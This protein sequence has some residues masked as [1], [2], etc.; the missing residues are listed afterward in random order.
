MS[1]YFKHKLL[2]VIIPTKNT[3]SGKTWKKNLRK[4][5]KMSFLLFLINLLDTK[6]I[7]LHWTYVFLNFNLHKLYYT[8]PFPL[9][10]VFS[11]RIEKTDFTIKRASSKTPICAKKKQHIFQKNVTYILSPC[12]K[13]AVGS[14]LS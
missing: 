5:S 12:H 14:L 9:L 7:Y 2:A 13:S 10:K 8:N 11:C 1:K 3:E 6:H 4:L